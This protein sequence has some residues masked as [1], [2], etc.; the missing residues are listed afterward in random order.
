[1]VS[2]K[3]VSKKKASKKKTSKKKVA[4]KLLDLFETETVQEKGEVPDENKMS[5]LGKYIEQHDVLANRIQRGEE[6]LKELKKSQNHILM[7]SIPELFE[8]MGN[9]E[10]FKLKDGR[11][12]KVTGDISI[13]IPSGKEE[14]AYS[15]FGD[16]DYGGIVKNMISV[17]TGKGEE[18]LAN[19]TRKALSRGKIAFDEKR[20]I[21]ASTLKATVK[22]L[23]ADGKKIPEDCFNLFSY[24]KT[25]IK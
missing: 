25:V 23:M 13:S 5:E 14:E 2:K 9:L 22:Q 20:G 15:F 21:H 7:V 1:M 11:T 18:E 6:L 24:S 19:K 4:S 12:I 10:S 3:K 17:A 8:S 16:N